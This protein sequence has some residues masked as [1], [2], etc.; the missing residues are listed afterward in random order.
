MPNM[1]KEFGID[2]AVVRAIPEVVRRKLAASERAAVE[3][4]SEETNIEVAAD[5]VEPDGTDILEQIKARI[6]REIAAGNLLPGMSTSLSLETPNGLD[7]LASQ[8]LA[9]SELL[10]EWH[11]P[12][13]RVHDLTSGEDT[14]LADHDSADEEVV[15]TDEQVIEANDDVET[16]E[17]SVEP[18]VAESASISE[19]FADAD[20][21]PENELAEQVHDETPAVDE[22][23]PESV[24]PLVQ[25]PKVSPSAKTLADLMPPISYEPL[26]EEADDVPGP[27]FELPNVPLTPPNSA[28]VEFDPSM[29][30]GPAAES[31]FE[32]DQ[33]DFESSPMDDSA[34]DEF[35]TE[36]TDGF[37]A[38]ASEDSATEYADT[39]EPVFR[40]P[41]SS[42]IAETPFV[43]PGLP[44][45]RKKRSV[46]RTLVG[47]ALGGLAG[48]IRASMRYCGFLD[49]RVTTCKSR[50]FC[51]A[52]SFQNRSSQ[53]LHPS[54]RNAAA[55]TR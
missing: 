40:E 13:V 50:S 41:N 16:N 9:E 45:P 14:T 3:P 28:T 34:T 30:F 32:L 19:Y 49:Q 38:E 47:A 46:A 54:S 31:E 39:D 17:D 20:A 33:V 48:S 18:I 24:E 22:L 2:Q 29:T 10:D 21:G 6:D 11:R 35:A 43:L 42:P 55:A 52:Q 1:P 53:L 12:T 26:H 5:A 44:R 27:S 51:P 15:E 7:D 4:V 36:S 25:S 23:A 37:A 8:P